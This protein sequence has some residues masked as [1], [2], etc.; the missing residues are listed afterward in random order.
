[1]PLKTRYNQLP[2]Q[3]PTSSLQ[4]QQFYNWSLLFYHW[5]TD[6]F[7][8]ANSRPLQQSD[9]LPIEEQNK[10]RISTEDLQN[11]WLEE[12]NACFGRRGKTPWLRRCVARILPRREIIVMILCG[13]EDA[14]PSTLQC[15]LLDLIRSSLISRNVD[16][17]VKDALKQKV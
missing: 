3:E 11:I 16:E 15:L 5:M 10:T 6:T 8:I 2:R 17:T 7:E 4:K 13:I 1:M 12:R 14:I 9:L